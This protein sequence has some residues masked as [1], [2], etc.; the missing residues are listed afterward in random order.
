MHQERDTDP[1]QQPETN[2]YFRPPSQ[3]QRSQPP[4]SQGQPPNQLPQQPPPKRGKKS[5]QGGQQLPLRPRKQDQQSPGS[6][7]HFPLNPIS[8]Q[9]K[10]NQQHLNSHD[11]SSPPLVPSPLPSSQRTQNQQPQQPAGSSPPWRPNLQNQDQFQRPQGLPMFPRQHHHPNKPLT[12][13]VAVFCAILWVVIIVGGLIV[14]IVYLVY[15]PRLPRFDISAATLNAAYLDMGYL[16]NADVT[17]LANFSNPNRKVNVDFSYM[18]IDL[19][20]GSTL[21]ATQY[22]QPFYATRAQS[23][24][25]YIHMVSSQVG[26][27]LIAARRLKKQI[28]ADAV[29]FQVKGYFR[30]RSTLGRL[31]KYSYLLHTHCNILMTGPPTGALIRSECKTKH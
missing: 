31:L 27:P 5:K 17:M 14:L 10:Q 15:R 7:D 11:P 24:F 21:I 6:A 23:K 28:E 1:N 19:Y 12:W 26:I 3:D 18:Y 16:L 13:F 30:A 22:V 20:Y 8:S 2:P 9:S 4:F 25:A 29:Q